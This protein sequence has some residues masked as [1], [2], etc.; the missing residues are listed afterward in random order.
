MRRREKD[1]SH[2]LINKYSIIRF[3]THTHT[4]TPPL[5]KLGVVLQNLLAFQSSPLVPPFSFSL[6]SFSVYIPRFHTARSHRRIQDLAENNG[7][8][9]P[10]RAHLRLQPF[11]DYLGRES[12]RRVSSRS[13]EDSHF[14]EEDFDA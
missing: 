1:F 4:H 5:S 7:I 11:A 3:H 8:V 14:A 9:N 12:N 13:F 10:S 2:F 6:S